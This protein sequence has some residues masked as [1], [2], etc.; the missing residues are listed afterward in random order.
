MAIKNLNFGILWRLDF[1]FSYCDGGGHKKTARVVSRSA[2]IRSK[3]RANL[4]SQLESKLTQSAAL[5]THSVAPVRRKVMAQ[6]T[7]QIPP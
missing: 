3:F 5:S 7:T 1:D 4:A 6:T 2:E